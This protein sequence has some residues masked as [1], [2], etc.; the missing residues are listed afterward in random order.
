MKRKIAILLLTL[1]FAC[2]FAAGCG[3]DG[4]TPQEMGYS[5]SVVFDANGGKFGE[6]NY[7]VRNQWVKPGSLLLEPGAPVM[8]NPPAPVLR[9]YDMMGWFKGEKS[10]DTVTFGEQW[11]FASDRADTAMTLYAK[12]GHKKGFSIR[13]YKTED[14]KTVPA[15]EKV[16]IDG[17]T[18]TSLRDPKW[19]GHTLMGYY[20]D[21]EKTLPVTFPAPFDPAQ[22]DENNLIPLYTEWMEG[23]YTLVRKASDMASMK[24]NGR[25]YLMNDIDFADTEWRM[26]INFSG[27]ING[28][29]GNYRIFNV[30]YA[31]TDPRSLATRNGLFGT[32]N[33]EARFVNVTIEATVKITLGGKDPITY[34]G[35]L[36]GEIEAGATFTNVVL[37]GSITVEVD[38]SVIGI[39]YA[40]QYVAAV[41]GT[42]SAYT[43]IDATNVSATKA[44]I[45]VKE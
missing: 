12:W 43:G 19:E 31:P 30:T 24:A 5:V 44:P 27:E 35:L 45:N 32:I 2:L 7:S 41:D 23:E 1:A 3:K 28:G 4:E 33:P 26:P 13:Y 22:A 8:N 37:K 16:Y 42:R 39:N 29:K 38:M 10:G 17:D 40:N 14:G 6:T 11:D 25:Y 34:N 18:L 36:A 9:G 21:E 15:E 20:W